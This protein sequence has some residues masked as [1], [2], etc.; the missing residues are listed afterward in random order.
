MTDPTDLEALALQAGA[1][2]MT[3][4]RL[5]WSALEDL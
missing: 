2:A 4:L 1:R 5:K 3:K